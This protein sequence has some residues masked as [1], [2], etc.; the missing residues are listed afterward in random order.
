M[1]IAVGRIQYGVRT[2][3]LVAACIYLLGP[4]AS[5]NAARVPNGTRDIDASL[6][7]DF[8]SSIERRD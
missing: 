3:G 7:S 1:R 8:V 4:A 5:N 6:Q 2:L